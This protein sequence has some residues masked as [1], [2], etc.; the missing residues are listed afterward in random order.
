MPL[1]C[2]ELMVESCTGASSS[3]V[4]KRLKY[5][6]QCLTELT[7]RGLVGASSGA[8][9][10]MLGGVTGV[11]GSQVAASAD[12]ASDGLVGG[13]LGV[14]GSDFTGASWPACCYFCLFLIFNR[15]DLLGNY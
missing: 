7:Q 13:V 11:P 10:G 15:C 3:A 2:T 5:M 6:G 9:D 12:S 14:P 1:S 4:M 8:A